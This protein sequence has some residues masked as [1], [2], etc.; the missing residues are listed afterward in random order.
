[1]S[2]ETRETLNRFVLVGN[3]ANRPAAWHNDPELR[4]RKGWADN[5][6]DDYIEMDT[7]IARLFNWEAEAV[8][9]ANLIPCDKKDA[10]FFG[11]QGQPFKVMPT[12]VWRKKPGTDGELLD[13]YEFHGLEQGIV[14]SD[15]HAHLATHG[16]GYKIHDYKE[17]L[18][19]LQ[20]KVIGAQNLSILGAGLL[21]QGLQAYVQVALPESVHD[22]STGLNFVPFMMIS[23]SLD[24]S[25]ATTISRQSLYVVCDNTRDCALRQSANAGMIYTAKHTARSLDWDRIQEVR[26][27][28][29]ILVDTAKDIVA[30]HK[31]LVSVKVTRGQAIKV[32]DIIIPLPDRDDNPTPTKIGRAK[33]RREAFWDTYTR[34]PMC[35]DYKGTAL[36]LLHAFNT[37]WTRKR[38]LNGDD[39]YRFQ[40][41][42]DATIRG[43][44]KRFDNNVVSAMAE[45]LNK[46]EWVLQN[47]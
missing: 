17:W 10:N 29:K 42:M 14:R 47:A 12:G 7:V 37:H 33:T 13:D 9:K 45:V 21:K 32:M 46:P 19:G 28:M 8:P 38:Q 24:G 25:M 43:A 3:C 1:M 30:E 41:N 5:H 20:A 44:T 11:P 31:E 22:S 36:G 4:R 39:F 23:T 16:S 6:F 40:K 15:T 34:D 35:S 26:D 2:R 27:S 18:L